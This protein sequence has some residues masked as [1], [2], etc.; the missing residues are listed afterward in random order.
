MVC[1]KTGHRI[2]TTIARNFAYRPVA[3]QGDYA[4]GQVLQ[5]RIIGAEPFALIAEPLN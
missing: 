4:P 1:E 5:A 2:G 3:L